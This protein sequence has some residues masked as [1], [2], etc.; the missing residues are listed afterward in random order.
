MVCH[1]SAHG[2]P[3]W[4]P[5]HYGPHG[6]PSQP[7]WCAVVVP[8]P[9]QPPWFATT[10]PM[11][12]RPPLCAMVVPV[13]QCHPHPLPAVPAVHNPC[14]GSCAAPPRHLTLRGDTADPPRAGMGTHV[15]LG[16]QPQPPPSAWG[17]G[18]TR[19]YSAGA[20]TPVG[21]LWGGRGAGYRTPFCA[22][23]PSP[24]SSAGSG[25][26][27]RERLWQTAAGQSRCRGGRGTGG[28]VPCSGGGGW[29]GW[30]GGLCARMPPSHCRGWGCRALPT[31]LRPPRLSRAHPP[32]RPPQPP[33]EPAARMELELLDL[34]FLTEAERCAIAEVLHRDALLR[35]TEEGRVRWDPPGPPVGGDRR[36]VSPGGSRTQWEAAA[37]PSLGHVPSTSSVSPTRSASPTCAVTSPHPHL[38]PPVLICHQP[39]YVPQLVRVPNFICAPSTSA[40]PPLV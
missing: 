39:F 6:A 19:P 21:F 40:V 11:P 18:A 2:V 33:P 30:R 1:H 27:R 17:Q 4:S 34:S 28:S 14:A 35:R 5:S 9:P 37:V 10:A 25:R 38:C 15:G 8:V 20:D 22:P 26:G 7:S 24:G 31:P 29:W 12:S 16:W 3:S 23:P 13:V 36:G 32:A